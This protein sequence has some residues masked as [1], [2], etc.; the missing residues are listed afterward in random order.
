MY[1]EQLQHFKNVENLGGKAWQHAVAL[2]LLTTADIQDCSIEC[3][4]YQHMFELLFK[5]VLETKSQFGA[6]SR[7]H[8]LQKLLEEV[9]ANTAFKTDKTQYLMAL[10][11]ITVCAEEYRYN[12][13]ID[14]DGY[15][16]SVAA[17][18]QLLKELLAFEKADHTARS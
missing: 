1:P 2:D 8:K 17:C 16:Q 14:C 12:F 5:H 9:I 6:Y 7:T 18:D 13:L 4:H 10:Q 15:R 3:L 11:V